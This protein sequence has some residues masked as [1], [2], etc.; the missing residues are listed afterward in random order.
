M[1]TAPDEHM[2]CIIQRETQR[3]NSNSKMLIPKDIRAIHP[4]TPPPPPTH[5]HYK[6]HTTQNLLSVQTL[7][8]SE[9]QRLDPQRHVTMKI[10]L[11]L[12]FL[13]ASSVVMAGRIGPHYVRIN[14][15][16]E[17]DAANNIE[18]RDTQMRKTTSNQG[19]DD[20]NLTGLAF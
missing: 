13:L 6:S 11:L 19:M 18:K 15:D 16:V 2:P 20:N 9:K 3:E 7:H 12:T 17:K 8:C 14:S 4:P 10:A 5:T 1:L